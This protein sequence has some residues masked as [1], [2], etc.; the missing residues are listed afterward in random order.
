MEGWTEVNQLGIVE[1][2]EFLISEVL[3]EAQVQLEKICCELPIFF[4]E[5]GNSF[6]LR[7][8]NQVVVVTC[9]FDETRIGGNFEPWDKIDVILTSGE[10]TE[11]EMYDIHDKD[12]LSY[13]IWKM[14]QG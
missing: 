1:G 12:P 13:A 4:L 7:Q 8:K 9:R 11:V 10:V 2:K 6:S 5:G 3:E 14:L